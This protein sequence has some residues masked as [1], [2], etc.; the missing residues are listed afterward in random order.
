MDMPDYH[1]VEDEDDE[2]H[3]RCEFCDIILSSI[4]QASDHELTCGYTFTTRVTYHGSQDDSRIM[5][6]WNPS[7]TLSPIAT[8]S[9]VELRIIHSMSM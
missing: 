8:N 2:D 7:D 6:D 3:L 5:R 9:K 1:Y 4:N